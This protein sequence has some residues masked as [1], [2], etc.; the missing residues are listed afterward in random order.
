MR[1]WDN[2]SDNEFEAVIGDLL[3]TDL[4]VRFERFARGP[5][6]GID[7]RYREGRKR[8]DI[9]QCKHYKG[10]SWSDLRRDAR[11][12]RTRL[13]ALKPQPRSY[14]FVTSLGLTPR[15]KTELTKIL[16]PY[17]REESHV[18]GRHD[19]EALLDAHEE[20]ERRHVKLWLASGPQLAALLRPG[21]AARSRM[22]AERVKRMLPLYVQGQS[23]FDARA[24][25]QDRHF[26]LI[27]GPPGI[28]KTTLAEMLIAEAIE[29]GY[30]PIEISEDVAE[31][32]DEID[33]GRRQIFLYDD[34]LG[35]TML[36][37][38]A[39]NE[40]SRLLGFIAAVVESPNSLFILTTREYILQEA[41]QQYESFR[42]YG[43]ERDRYLL[44]LPSYSPLERARILHNHIWR[45]D[46][47]GR[48]ARESLVHDAG[49][50]RIVE[51]PGFKPRTIEYI[52]GLQR[53]HAITTNNWLD[54]AVNALDHPDEI[55]RTAHEELG[56]A[57]RLLLA[58]LATFPA[59]AQIDDLRSA[60]AALTESTGLASHPKRFERA[61]KVLDDSFVAVRREDDGTLFVDVHDP[62]LADFLQAQLVDDPPT[63]V[64]AVRSAQFFEQL[65]HLW[66]VTY[67]GGDPARDA[68]SRSEDFVRSARRL[69]E[70]ESLIWVR[71]RRDARTTRMTRLRFSKQS[72]VARLSLVARSRLAPEGLAGYVEECLAELVRQWWEGAIDEGSAMQLADTLRATERP[73]APHDWKLAMK[74]A[75]AS[76]PCYLDAWEALVA[77]HGQFRQLFDE[78]EWRE[79]AQRFAEF[80]DAE[81]RDSAYYQTDSDVDRLVGC[82]AEFEVVLDDQRIAA[83]RRR[84]AGRKLATDGAALD[85]SRLTDESPQLDRAAQR[86]EMDA[87]FAGLLDQV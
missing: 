75:L 15:R 43:L 13:A 69:L 12:E 24:I 20:V 76:D 50:R 58:T 62:G 55:W 7:L 22:L 87:M 4:A 78:G 70:S 81:L 66:G 14:R 36:G 40:D 73:H 5:D 30:E 44:E 53:G 1:N 35:H 54:F 71:Q 28:G 46:L 33:Q 48:A 52:T 2:I 47:I 25:L 39:K 64:H 84:I 42:R 19:L 56:R 32:W 61:L 74:H 17:V 29:Q 65:I 79:L 77:F 60:F 51:H 23:F 83:I 11:K 9:V 86:R 31:G 67:E 18:Y 82:A 21:T 27:A 34:F 85:L 49:Y 3:G 57:E 41:T 37:E 26:C 6:M 16:V 72:R 63:L 68:L 59:T 10:G 8:P 80:A 45:S 38:L